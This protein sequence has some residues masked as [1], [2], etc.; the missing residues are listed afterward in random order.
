MGSNSKRDT[1]QKLSFKVTR[2][3]SHHVAPR[4]GDRARAVTFTPRVPAVPFFSQLLQKLSFK[5][6]RTPSHHVAPRG[7]D[8]ARAVTF[9]LKSKMHFASN[10]TP[11][12][13]QTLSPPPFESY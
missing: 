10:S 9:T 12:P 13:S 2:T 11:S 3:P 7:G 6:T 5:V 4:G 1:A 8:R